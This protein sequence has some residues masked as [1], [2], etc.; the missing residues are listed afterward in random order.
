MCPLECEVNAYADYIVQRGEEVCN[1]NITLEW[2]GTE[3]SLQFPI[4]ASIAAHVLSNTAT[5]A[6]VEQLFPISGR[7]VCKARSSLSFRHI[8]EFYCLHQWLVDEGMISKSAAKD[9]QKEVKTSRKIAFINL[10]REVEPER[11]EKES[12]DED[13]E[14]W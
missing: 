3:G 1:A 7:I 14:D 4:L 12:D 6:S 8:N 5:S 9:A 13:D 11:R 2:W 10:R